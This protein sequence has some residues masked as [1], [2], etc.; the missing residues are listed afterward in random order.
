MN[1][2]GMVALFDAGWQAK[3]VRWFTAFAL[4]VC[5]GCLYWGYD[6]SQT[7]GLSPGDGGVGGPRGR[8][9]GGGGF[10]LGRFEEGHGAPGGEF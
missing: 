9:V 2:D 6:L 4:V 10:D 8:R 3:K 1:M 7:Y 5:L